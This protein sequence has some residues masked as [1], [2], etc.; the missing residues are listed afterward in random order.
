MFVKE[1][2]D[3]E[4]VIRFVHPKML[5]VDEA[6]VLKRRKCNCC[7]DTWNNEVTCNS[8]ITL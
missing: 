5:K 7:N 2:T 8:E 1:K 3:R 4:H 6:V